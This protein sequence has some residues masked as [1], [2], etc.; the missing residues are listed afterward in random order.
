MSSK[1]RIWTH[2]KVI[3]RLS[4]SE[5]QETPAAALWPHVLKKTAS[6]SIRGRWAKPSCSWRGW[7]TAPQ[8][9]DSLLEKLMESQTLLLS[10]HW[11]LAWVPSF[12][13]PFPPQLT[14]NQ[15][16][17]LTGADSCGCGSRGQAKPL[18]ISCTTLTQSVIINLVTELGYR[19]LLLSWGYPPS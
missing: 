4:L 18:T 1:F 5:Q 12:A 19:M 6:P 8:N 15:L 7:E 14:S 16:Q 3:C 17:A 9:P 11:H 13:K 10:P 2:F